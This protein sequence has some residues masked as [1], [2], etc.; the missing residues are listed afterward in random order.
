MDTDGFT[1]TTNTTEE[2][3]VTTTASTSEIDALREQISA[4]REVIDTL[5]SSSKKHD[6]ND[7][8]TTSEPIDEPVD[9]TPVLTAVQGKADQHGF[10]PSAV[11]VVRPD[12]PPEPE[13]EPLPSLASDDVD[14]S[15]VDT[16]DCPT[17]TNGVRPSDD[18]AV[19]QPGRWSARRADHAIANA[20][21]KQ[22]KW[23]VASGLNPGCV[24][25]DK[26]TPQVSVT[27]WVAHAN[28]R[29]MSKAQVRTALLRMEES[30]AVMR[31]GKSGKQDV[32]TLDPNG[33]FSSYLS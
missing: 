7:D 4:L 20:L 3:T 25:Q 16:S 22:A 27:D 5:A 9:E 30:N 1:I 24:I 6:E 18:T 21:G 14:A 12:A 2:V 8:S 13:P 10:V 11:E 32:W 23:A 29:R 28:A 19:Y 33:P 15:S 26:Y 17:F 31:T